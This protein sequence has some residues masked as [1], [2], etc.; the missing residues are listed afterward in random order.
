MQ[1]RKSRQLIYPEPMTI[2][3]LLLPAVNEG[4]VRRI[5]DRTRNGVCG[6]HS[7]LQSIKN[8]FSGQGF[9]HA[10]GVADVQKVWVFRLDC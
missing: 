1:D 2:Q 10:S 8:P 9:D 6:K 7:A 3:L 5:G 4:R